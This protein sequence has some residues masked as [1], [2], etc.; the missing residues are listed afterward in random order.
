MEN[1]IAGYSFEE[2]EKIQKQ[3]EKDFANS[4]KY[5]KSFREMICEI[6]EGE[7]YQSFE[8]KTG[9]CPNMFY[10]LKHSVDEKDPCQ[11]NTLLTVCIAYN[12]DLLMTQAL[13]NSLGL[14]FN[15]HS[16]RDSAYAYLLT[17]CRGK[18]IN[19]CNEILSG[20]GIPKT[21]WL[22]VHARNKRRKKK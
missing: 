16:R 15:R 20:L 17:R 6:L 21:Y 3:F 7:T 5:N 22:G 12:L 10:R 1:T 11:R 4:T 9:L 8:C 19:E 14:E 13:L 18:S 2:W